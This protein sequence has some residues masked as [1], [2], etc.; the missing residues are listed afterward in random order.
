[1]HVYFENYNLSASFEYLPMPATLGRQKAEEQSSAGCSVQI[2]GPSSC[3]LLRRGEAAPAL[4]VS[5]TLGFSGCGSHLTSLLNPPAR[6]KS[7]RPPD[8]PPTF[9][10]NQE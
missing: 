8:K 5:Q 2:L 3:S 1:M 6:K 9:H 10:P 7:W 4:P